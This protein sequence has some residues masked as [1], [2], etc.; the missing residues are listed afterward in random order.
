MDINKFRLTPDG[1]EQP[2][3]RIY[4]DVRCDEKPACR[5]VSLGGAHLVPMAR[6]KHLLPF[7]TQKLSSS[8]AIILR[9]WETST[10]PNYKKDF[11]IVSL[12][13]LWEIFTSV[14]M[15]K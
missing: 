12:F 8:A 1:E 14:A 10:V 11:R 15:Q 9:K 6:G 3:R 4:F 13:F 2:E 7:R 5:G